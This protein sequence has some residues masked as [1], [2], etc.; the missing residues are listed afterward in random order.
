MFFFVGSHDLS[1]L[2]VAGSYA[3]SYS[4]ILYSFPCPMYGK[5]PLSLALSPRIISEVAKFKPD[6]IHASSPG[7]MVT[8]FY[9][10]N[11]ICQIFQ[12]SVAEY[13][14]S[15]LLFQVFGALAIAKLLGVPLVMS[16]HTHVPVY[17]K[18]WYYCVIFMISLPWLAYRFFTA[19]IIFLFSPAD[20][21]QDIH[22]AGL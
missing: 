4:L 8:I 7:I 9:N 19:S 22:L 14:L 3:Y 2:L 15:Q 21:Y 6:I 13:D 1:R 5:V 12:S 20:T 11:I 10:W 18:L 17:V 16:Y